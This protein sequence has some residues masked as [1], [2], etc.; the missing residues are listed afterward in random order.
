[1]L[2]IL[3]P[4]LIGG[5]LTGGVY[6]LVAL[7]LTLIYGVLH[8]VNFAH[9]SLLMIA[10]FG[11]WLLADALALDPLLALPLLT[12]IMFAIGWALYAGVIEPRRA[13]ATTARSCSPRSASPSCSTMRRWS[14]FT[15]DTRTVETPY[16]FAMIDRR[17]RAGADGQA[18]LLRL[19]AG[20]RRACSGPSWRSPIPAARS[21]PSPRSRRAR[22]WSASGRTRIFALAYGI[23]I[24][25]LGAAG[26]PAAADLLCQPAGRQRLRAASPSP[27]WCSAAWA[28]FPARWSAAC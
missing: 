25:C 22:A 10:M 19:R 21:A 7:G 27:S 12:A 8:I 14:L 11:A 6:A 1:M 2:D 20:A 23:G 24:A 17:P 15:G 9:G 13:V 18:D 4:A 3:L 26:V 28:A 16:S 5:L